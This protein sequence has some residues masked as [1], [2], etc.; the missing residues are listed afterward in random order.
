R[1][2]AGLQDERELLRIA[3]RAPAHVDLRAVVAGDAV[4][5]A[6]EVDVGHRLDLPVEHDRKVLRAALHG[7][8][9][10]V[11]GA[12][13][14]AALCL[15]L[16]DLLTE[17]ALRL[18]PLQKLRVEQGVFRRQRAGLDDFLRVEEVPLRGL[19]LVCKGTRL[20]RRGEIEEAAGR[21]RDL[22]EPVA[23]RRP[24]QKIGR[25]T[26]ELQSLAYLVCRLLLEKKK[27][28][29]NI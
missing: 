13:V 28:N 17:T 29:K 9:V 1:Q 8:R 22:R 19:S 7:G 25:D 24:R 21:D 18:R 26:S 20:R 23:D 27:K 12:C 11:P 4:R 6:A 14:R 16:R 2:R 15:A 10:V 5:V 3:E